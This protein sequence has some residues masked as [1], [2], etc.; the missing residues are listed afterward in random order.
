MRSQRKEDVR[1]VD[2]NDYRTADR[3]IPQ[4]LS[5]QY[6]EDDD[7]EGKRNWSVIVMMAAMLF[8]PLAG[9]LAFVS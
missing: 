3:R 2:F 6:S 5:D 4:P 9:C 7:F 1:V 8:A